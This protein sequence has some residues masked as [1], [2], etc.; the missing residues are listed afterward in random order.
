MKRSYVLG[1]FIFAKY[2]ILRLHLVAIWHMMFYIRKIFMATTKEL[3]ISPAD[4]VPTIKEKELTTYCK[5]GIVQL[6]RLALVDEKGSEKYVFNVWARGTW[7]DKSE[8]LLITHNT[9]RPRQWSSLDK[10]V[11]HIREVYDYKG[12]VL[13]DL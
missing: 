1:I 8:H 4:Q 3:I 2:I 10:A 5:A 9:K 7:A 12:R 6:I 11:K 13:L